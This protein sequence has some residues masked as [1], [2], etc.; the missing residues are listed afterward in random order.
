LRW[1]AKSL[2]EAPTGGAWS[3]AQR[4]EVLE[5]VDALIYGGRALD[6]T[7][8]TVTITDRDGNVVAEKQL[9]EAPADQD[10]KFF[11]EEKHV[12]YSS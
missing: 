1:T 5:A 2:E 10:I 12:N 8:G 4:D 3:D 6:I 11:P 7:G 9:V